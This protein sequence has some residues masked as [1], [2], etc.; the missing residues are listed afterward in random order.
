MESGK[1]F[2]LPIAS[3]QLPHNIRPVDVTKD[4]G[5]Q[6]NAEVSC[7]LF[8]SNKRFTSSQS[9]GL[10]FSGSLDRSIK[11]WSM[12]VGN[13]SSP[14]QTLF[15]HSSTISKLVDG[16]D[17]TVLSCSEDGS[18]RMWSPQRGRNIMMHPFKTK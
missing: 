7:L 2:F 3:G 12:G 10:L 17:G 16:T 5:T 1:I 11:I 15:G 8:S 4:S 18:L 14:V 6:H 13:Q 9:T